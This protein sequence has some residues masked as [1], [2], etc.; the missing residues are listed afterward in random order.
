MCSSDLSR[1]LACLLRCPGV[2]DY[3]VFTVDGGM[4]AVTLQP[5]DAAVVGP[6][7]IVRTGGGA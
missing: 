6:V 2:A 4:A 7:S 1:F 3:S 5:E